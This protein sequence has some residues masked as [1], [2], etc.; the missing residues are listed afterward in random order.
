MKTKITYRKH[1]NSTVTTYVGIVK[2]YENGRYLFSESTFIHR[3]NPSDA[4]KD[5]KAI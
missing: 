5:A 1:T 3:L 4:K 2:H